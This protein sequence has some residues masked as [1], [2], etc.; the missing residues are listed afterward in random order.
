MSLLTFCALS[1]QKVPRMPGFFSPLCNLSSWERFLTEEKQF[2]GSG[3]VI[4]K[5]LPFLDSESKGAA[6]PANVD[7]CLNSIFGTCDKKMEDCSD[8]VSQT[9]I[10]PKAFVGYYTTVRRHL[11]VIGK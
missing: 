2:D 8:S 1:S 5:K 4:R 10:Q 6:L 11:E 7:R 9:S 3:N